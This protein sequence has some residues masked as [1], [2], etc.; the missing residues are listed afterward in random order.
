MCGLKLL[1]VFVANMNVIISNW[2][3]RKKC[4]KI[5]IVDVYVTMKFSRIESIE[6]K[7]RLFGRKHDAYRNTIEVLKVTEL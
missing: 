5:N 1:Y 4:M 3:S 2:Q 7:D 6:I